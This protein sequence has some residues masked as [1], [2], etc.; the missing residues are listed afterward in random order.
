MN[1]WLVNIFVIIIDIH[2]IT[3]ENQ[4]IIKN[5]EN[6][7][8]K[9]QFEIADLRKKLGTEENFKNKLGE[10]LK[11]KKEEINFLKD[12][13]AKYKKGLDEYGNEVKWNQDVVG[14]KDSQLKVLKEKI[15]KLE[16]ENKRLTKNYEN[17]KNKKKI[18]NEKEQEYENE[19]VEL[20]AKPFLFGPETDDF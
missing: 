11:K 15:K 9:L 5:Q 8:T 7:I 18:I 16:E 1:K 2:K 6:S 17:L 20:K 13:L 4:Y 19:I 10:N 3:E 14:Q 12:E